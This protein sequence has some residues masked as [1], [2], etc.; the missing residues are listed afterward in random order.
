M[1]V[2]LL[3][4]A[5]DPPHLG[6]VEL[7][8]EVLSRF[9]LEQLVV[10]VTGRAPHKVVETGAETRLS[11]AEAAFSDLEG[12]EVSRWEIDRGELSYTVDTVRWAK[13]CWGDVAFIVGADEFC[14]FLDWKDP[15]GVLEHARLLVASRP[16]FPQERLDRVLA[17][18]ARPERVELFEIWPMPIS[19]REIR[20]RVARGEPIDDA[21]PSAVGEL[22]E[23]LGLYEG[24]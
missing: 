15:D 12:V 9:D 7:A 5:F 6:H 8:R 21:V 11:L 24:A 14:D 3:G 19:S 22:I 13:D 20:A 2:G 17:G 18:L 10:V 23:E 1:T 16:G 4:G